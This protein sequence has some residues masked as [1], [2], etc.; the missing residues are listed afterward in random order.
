MKDGLATLL[1]KLVE[2]APEIPWWRIMYAFPGYVTDR[3]IDVM[4]SYPQI[5]PYL[6]MPLQHAHPAIL[7]RMRR[8]A[9]M[10][11]VYRTLEK[12]RAAMPGLALRST[13]IVGYPGESEA[14]FAAL[15]D[16]V[17]SIRFERLGAFQFSFEAGTA[18]ESLGDPIPTELKQTRWE[19]L[20]ELQHGI[21]LEKNQAFV[22]QTLQI[23][24]EGQGELQAERHASLWEDD[25]RQP[26]G[27]LSVGR[28]YRDAPEIDGVVIVEGDLQVGALLPVKITGAM[29]YDLS[30]LYLPQDQPLP[31]IQTQPAG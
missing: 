15:L 1:E 9:N 24:V 10:K 14:E 25:P 16:F 26:L 4:A 28:S 20:M 23:L 27:K 21:S 13:F 17:R 2:Q 5:L 12:M 19:R 8:P 7:K 3:L 31:V 11:W 30:A 22:G 6:D 18:S 29:P